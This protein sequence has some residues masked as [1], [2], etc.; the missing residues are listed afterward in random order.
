[1]QRAGAE[2]DFAPRGR[3]KDASATPVVD[4]GR[5]HAVERDPCGM[6]VGLHVEVGAPTG[7]TEVR[8]CG[9]RAQAV[10][11]RQ[12]VVADALLPL[13]VE[14]V[15]AG[16]TELV[17]CADQRFD[18]R[19]SALDVRGPQRAVGAVEFA[20][21]AHVVL[22]LAEIG[23]H[24]GEAPSGIAERRPMVVIVAL[25]ANVDESIDRRRA[26][27]RAPARPIHVAPIHL[28]LGLGVEAPIQRRM[29]H[30]FR[31][32]D[33]N[34]DPRIAIARTRFEEQHRVAAIRGKAV[35]ENAA[36]GAGT[37]N[38]VVVSGG[39]GHEQRRRWA[40]DGRK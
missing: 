25:A 12:L 36:G 27:Q 32:S 8:G 11:R 3:R 28:R 30:R 22:E 38:D 19:M 34:V 23:Q 14:V 2:N 20:C 1:M 5:A 39:R 4:A 37:R 35:G 24:V 15:V 31:V 6:R 40:R 26:A 13:P 17:G 18:Q 21:A 9:R 16:Y 7:R 33:R 29:E 10:S